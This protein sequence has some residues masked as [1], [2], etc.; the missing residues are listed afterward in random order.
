VISLVTGASG[1][2]GSHV[3]RQLVA[4]G[5]RVRV[6]AR[7]TSRLEAISDLDVQCVTGELREPSS[8]DPAL[9]GVHR[10]FHVAADYRL[11]ASNPREIYQSNV[12][13]TRNLLAASRRAR[14]ERFV[15]TSTVG[16]IA[17]PGPSSLPNE[18]TVARL[19][20]MIGHY[21]RSKFLAEREAM[22][23]A[24]EGLPV[25]IVNP[26][27]PVGP[28]DWKPT[29]TGRMIVDFLNGRTPAYVDSGLNI[30]AVEDVAEG[31]WLAAERG[32][33]GERY[34]LGGENMTLQEIFGILAHASGRRA[35]KWKM[36]H[37]FALAAGYADALISKIAA[38]EPRIPLEGVR[39]AR[40]KMFVDC[41]KAIRELGF[42]AGPADAALERAAQ[43]YIDH[44]YARTSAAATP[45]DLRKGSDCPS[46]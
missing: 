41:S 29:P 18:E 4:K 39:M 35:P 15:Y 30:V 43:W 10:V 19:N 38:R 13:G 20:Q 45:P 26:T 33:T 2:L 28:G 36:P 34:L 23:A 14:V 40:H 42:C 9:E 31:H 6:L 7:P 8:L 12:D 25:V 24:R 37:A 46:G 32:R 1:F 5:S 27:T 21:K 22:R 44:G 16:T 11:W 17:V 3:T